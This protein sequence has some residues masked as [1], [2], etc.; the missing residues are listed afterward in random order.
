MATAEA[1]E[2]AVEAAVAVVT[3][4][5]SAAVVVSTAEVSGVA[6]LVAISVQWEADTRSPA[7]DL[8]CRVAATGMAAIGV[9]SAGVAATG[10]AIGIITIIIIM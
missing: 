4:A 6:V 10:T 7:A 5:A 8:L 9:A 3:E 1:A 2:A